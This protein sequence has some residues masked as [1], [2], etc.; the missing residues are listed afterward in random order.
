MKTGARFEKLIDEVTLAA[1]VEE[2]GRQIATDYRDKDL[3]LISVLKGSFLFLADLC[4]HIDLPLTIDFMG[5]SS[6]GAHTTSS[7]VVQITQDLTS[8]IADKDVL[9]VE[10]I[11]D[12]GLTLSFLLDNFRLRHP[13]SLRICSLLHKPT[14]TVK[15]VPLDYVGFVVSDRF[16]VGYGLDFEQRFRNLPY[17]AVIPDD[18][19]GLM[20]E[21]G[22]RVAG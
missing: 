19:S 1:R 11:V 6:Y 8:P 2:L 20:L 18:S 16:V 14:R 12:T 21:T 10:D 9:V 17:V 7:G 4:R 13:R 5:L 15:P 3:V 22:N